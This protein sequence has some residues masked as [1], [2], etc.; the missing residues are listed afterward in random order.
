MAAGASWW[1]AATTAE[2]RSA[3]KPTSAREIKETNSLTS[4]ETEILTLITAGKSNGEIAQQLHI[5]VGT[6]RVH[7]HA[8]LQ[9]GFKLKSSLQSWKR[10]RQATP[11]QPIKT[12]PPKKEA[13]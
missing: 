8:I 3:F 5:T 10:S 12:I 2:I 4:R 11:A 6:V 9:R 7:V 13:T 1:D